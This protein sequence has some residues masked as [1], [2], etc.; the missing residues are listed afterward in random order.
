MLLHELYFTI[1]H[2]SN[3]CIL[4]LQTLVSTD[5]VWKSKTTI[6]VDGIYR[7]REHFLKT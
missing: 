2:L 3:V 6:V 4:L 7:I 5:P 1:I